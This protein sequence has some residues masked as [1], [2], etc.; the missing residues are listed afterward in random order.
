MREIKDIKDEPP[1]TIN[2]EEVFVHLGNDWLAIYTAE[3]GRW[4][5]P[6]RTRATTMD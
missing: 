5:G 2:G 4:R 6:Y 1:P 3:G